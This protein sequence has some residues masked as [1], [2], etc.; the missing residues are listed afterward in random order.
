MFVDF[1]SPVNIQGGVA[2]IFAVATAM[3][4]STGT[5][6]AICATIS[7]ASVRASWLEFSSTEQE[8]TIVNKS[9]SSGML[10]Y[11]AGYVQCMIS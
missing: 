6:K 11:L 7:A 4:L 5:L 10:K 2:T 9:S 1:R 8:N 3:R